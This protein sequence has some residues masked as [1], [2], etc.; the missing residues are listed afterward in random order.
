MFI[1]LARE[2]ADKNWL[3]SPESTGRDLPR[4]TPLPESRP[5]RGNAVS[6]H[7]GLRQLASWPCPTCPGHFSECW[8]WCAARAWCCTPEFC[9]RPPP[10]SPFAVPLFQFGQTSAGLVALLGGLTGLQEVFG[11]LLGHRTDR[12]RPAAELVS[13]VGEIFLVLRR[14]MLAVHQR[15]TL[16]GCSRRWLATRLPW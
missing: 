4:H 8:Q 16:P 11:Y 13:V 10:A 7:F 12:H 6:H 5:R 9:C 3:R 14:H 2:F 1:Q 15:I